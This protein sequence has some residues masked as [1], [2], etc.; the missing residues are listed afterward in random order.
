MTTV[1]QLFIVADM[2]AIFLADAHLR[3]PQDNN[4]QLLLDFLD[5]QKELDALFL[6]GDIFEF[7]I[8]YK[9]LAFT[10][11][12]PLL[13]QL[14]RLSESGTKLFFVEGNHDFHLGSYF[15]ETLNCTVIPDQQQ[16]DWDG[17]KIMISHGDLLNPDRYYRYLRSFYYQ[18]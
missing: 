11:Y 5:Q 9:H 7:W 12:I 18:G 16:V 13:E 6:L 1:N 3:H 14:R 15:T 10:T 8:G 4:Y 17:L 2:K